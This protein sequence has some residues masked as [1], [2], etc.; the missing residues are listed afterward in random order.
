MPLSLVFSFQFTVPAFMIPVPKTYLLLLLSI[1]LKTSL[2][3][4]TFVSSALNL[5]ALI[6]DFLP[7]DE[8]GLVPPLAANI[9]LP[10]SKLLWQGNEHNHFLI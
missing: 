3:T 10:S 2:V 5:V 8:Y 9:L 7:R 6:S 4:F 1:S